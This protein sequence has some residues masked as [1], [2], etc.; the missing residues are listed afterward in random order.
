M[1]NIMRKIPSMVVHV[2]QSP[3]C[4]KIKFGRNVKPSTCTSVNFTVKLVLIWKFSNELTASLV[5]TNI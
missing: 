5:K 1:L 3:V 2:L 4:L